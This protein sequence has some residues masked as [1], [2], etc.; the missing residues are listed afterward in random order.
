ML[1]VRFVL[2]LMRIG[3][4]NEKEKIGFGGGSWKEEKMERGGLSYSLGS[5]RCE[6]VTLTVEPGDMN[7]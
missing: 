3:R 4:G 1:H 2:D 7:G 6:W 5:I